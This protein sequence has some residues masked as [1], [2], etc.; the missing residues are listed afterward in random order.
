MTQPGSEVFAS[1]M[2]TAGSN[3]TS[4]D[5]LDPRDSI[6]QGHTRRL[7]VTRRGEA[8]FQTRCW[9]RSR[10]DRTYRPTCTAQPSISLR[11]GSGRECV[12]VR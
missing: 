4:V 1:R 11:P 2:A 10:L 8:G 6:H 3:S 5:V 12:W 7:P 9:R